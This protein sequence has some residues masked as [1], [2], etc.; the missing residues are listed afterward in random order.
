[1]SIKTN[2]ITNDTIP[3]RMDSFPKVGP[4]I[5]SETITA[6]A[7]N[8]PAWLNLLLLPMKTHR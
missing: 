1:M 3:S 7:G 5:S 2:A 8:F 6:G 4:T